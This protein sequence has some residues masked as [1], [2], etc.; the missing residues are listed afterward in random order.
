LIPELDGLSYFS[1]FFSERRLFGWNR[2]DLIGIAGIG[3]FGGVGFGIIARSLIFFFNFGLEE[4]ESF[5]HMFAICSMCIT[6]KCGLL[7]N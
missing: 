2:F 7:A 4:I 5:V 6:I 3:N 1:L